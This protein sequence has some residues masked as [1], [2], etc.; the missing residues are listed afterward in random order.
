MSGSRVLIIDD[1]PAIR[2]LCRVNL[3]AEGFSVDEA[4][5]GDSG[6]A[7]ARRNRPDAILLDV[8]L[9]GDDGFAVA[10]RLH[11]D[12]DLAAVPIIFLTARADL[13]EGERLRR[14]GAV[15]FLTKP[16]NPLD[17]AGAVRRA[18]S[19]DR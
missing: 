8:M 5:D 6:I 7:A 1:E 2:L 11:A 9:P 3:E 12:P 10:D 4:G 14:S 13:D 19:P 16:F 17:L 18:Q 15:G